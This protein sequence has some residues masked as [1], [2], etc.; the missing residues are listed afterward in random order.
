MPFHVFENNVLVEI[1]MLFQFDESMSADKDRMCYI[2]S[3]QSIKVEQ[4]IWKSDYCNVLF[5]FRRNL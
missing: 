2:T 5:E 4:L 1:R 3:S